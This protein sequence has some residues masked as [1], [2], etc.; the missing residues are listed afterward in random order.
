[1]VSSQNQTAKSICWLSNQ[2]RLKDTVPVVSD[3]L[4]PPPPHHHPLV[5]F[6]APDRQN[7]WG[8]VFSPCRKKPYPWSQIKTWCLKHFSGFISPLPNRALDLQIAATWV[9]VFQSGIVAIGPELCKMCQSVNSSSASGVTE[10]LERAPALHHALDGLL[11]C[12]SWMTTKMTHS[13]WNNMIWAEG[14]N[15]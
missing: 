15:P 6:P 12:G 14:S 4:S 1:M 9:F 3:D 8:I 5:L 7:V 11:A 10:N 13:V 2:M